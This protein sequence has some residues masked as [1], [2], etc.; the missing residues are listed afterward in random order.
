M[1]LHYIPNLKVYFWVKELQKDTKITCEQK[2]ETI[3]KVI[4][5]V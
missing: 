1:L 4:V 2:I 3:N 5:L